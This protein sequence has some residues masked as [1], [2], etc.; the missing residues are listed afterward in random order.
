MEERHKLNLGRIGIHISRETDGNLSGSAAIPS[1]RDLKPLYLAFRFFYHEKEPSNFYR[2][3]NI[4]VRSIQEPII[5]KFVKKIKEQWRG[6]FARNLSE[7]H[8]RRHYTS[9]DIIDNWFNAHYFH[10]DENKEIKLE[11][12]NTLLGPELSHISL[13]MAVFDASLAVSNLFNAIENMD[14]DK[15]VVVLPRF[16]SQEGVQPSAADGRRDKAVPPLCP[17]DV[18]SRNTRNPPHLTAMRIH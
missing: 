2:V 10:S 12:L 7:F 1:D 3:A 18:Q 16:M 8:G 9:K 5:Q 14:R 11:E 15:G 4:L 6:S 17:H 13:F